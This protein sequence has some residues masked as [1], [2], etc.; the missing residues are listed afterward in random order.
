MISHTSVLKWSLLMGA[1]YF[2]AVA[3]AHLL[4]LK[5][6]VLFVYYSLPSYSYQDKIIAFLSFG[7]ALFLFRAFVDP[8]KQLELIRTILL[9][10]LCALLGLVIINSTTDFRLMLPEVNPAVFWWETFGLSAYFAW[11]VVFYRRVCKEISG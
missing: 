11:L 3:M 2:F 9:A 7:W 5:I 10:G 8:T 6:P 1:V 4:N